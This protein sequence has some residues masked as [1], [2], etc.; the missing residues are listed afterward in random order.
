MRGG[1]DPTGGHY[2]A[3]HFAGCSYGRLFSAGSVLVASL[4]HTTVFL[5][6]VTVGTTS[7]AQTITLG[8]GSSTPLSITSLAITGTNASDFAEIADT[9]GPSLAA[10]GTCT[11]GVTFTPSASGQR[12]GTL[13]ITD[14][15]TGSPQTASFTGTGNP[16][17]ILSWGASPSSGVAGY[18][19]YRGTSSAGQRVAAL[20]VS[21]TAI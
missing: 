15:A 4:S 5:G 9:C 21:A 10:G 7:A 14:N 8:N 1:S 3:C 20:H 6:S 12:T 13:S 18:N 16:D 17:V 19:V 11:I 2:S